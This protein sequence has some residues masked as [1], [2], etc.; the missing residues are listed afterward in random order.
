MKYELMIREWDADRNRMGLEGM[1]YAEREDYD[2]CIRLGFSH[3]E[4]IEERVLES[5]IGVCD[6]RERAIYENDIVRIEYL[7]PNCE[8][9]RMY[10]AVANQFDTKLAGYDI[11]GVPS[12]WNDY[13]FS[14]G[15]RLQQALVD[16]RAIVTVVGNIHEHGELLQ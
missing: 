8:V 14:D 10:A 6:D 9:I 15:N 2:D 11:V 7:K 4:S 12:E 13:Y 16:P 1:S 5:F 3:I